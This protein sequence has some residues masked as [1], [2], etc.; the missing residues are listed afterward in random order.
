M[1]HKYYTTDCMCNVIYIEFCQFNQFMLLIKELIK[2]I[3]SEQRK[4]LEQ[5]AKMEE[6]TKYS[7]LF[8]QFILRMFTLGR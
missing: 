3:D 4:D 8:R 6:Q 7:L 1:Y 2:K 5:F